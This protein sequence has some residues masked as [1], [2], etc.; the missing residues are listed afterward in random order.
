[1]K[2]LIVLLMMFIVSLSANNTTRHVDPRE[3][4][5]SNVYDQILETGIEF[6]DIVW[7]QAV[8]ESGHFK[9]KV[10]RNNN[11]LFGMRL[12]KKRETLASGSNL[13]YAMYDFWEESIADYWL[14]QEYVFRKR[15]KMSREQ[16]LSH[17]GRSYASNPQ[18]VSHLLGVIKKNR[19]ILRE[20]PKEYNDGVFSEL[21]D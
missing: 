21:S 13:G 14:Y 17:L 8:L 9:S 3:V 15:T 6:P 4:S 11:N 10:F 19:K 18:Y 20:V 1:M 2:R 16:Y 7:A 12:P 5:Y